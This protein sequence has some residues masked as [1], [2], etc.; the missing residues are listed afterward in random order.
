MRY[1]LLA[2][3]LLVFAACSKKTDVNP[4]DPVTQVAGS[5]NMT[6]LRYDS[7]GV[8]IYNLTLP[9]TGPLIGSMVVRRD[10][11]AVISTTYTVKQ[12]GSADIRDTFGQLTLKGIASP[13]DIYYGDAKIGSTDGK[14]FT[15][16]YAYTEDGITYREVYSGQKNLGRKGR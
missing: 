1:V 10:S 12:P 3:V 15:I 14:T 2:F 11:A 13:Y 7:A 16:D 6:T 4:H 8:T 5:Y 9:V